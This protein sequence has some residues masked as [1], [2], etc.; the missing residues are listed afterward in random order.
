M[1]FLLFLYS[2]W[3]QLILLF[4]A[5][6]QWSPMRGQEET[7]MERVTSTSVADTKEVHLQNHN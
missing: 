6:D 1:T 7:Q 3:N 2:L 4:E 5:S